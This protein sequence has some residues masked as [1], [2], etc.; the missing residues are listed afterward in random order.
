VLTAGLVCASLTVLPS[1]A[2][3]ATAADGDLVVSA[4]SQLDT[5]SGT[6]WTAGQTSPVMGTVV[7]AA[8]GPYREFDFGSVRID[9]GATL[10]LVGPYPAVIHAT[11]DITIAGT[12]DGAGNDT[13]P[14]AGGGRGGT[15]NSY[16]AAEGGAGASGG[17]GGAIVVGQNGLPGES[18][19]GWIGGLGGIALSG[20][21]GGG[22]G[23]TQGPPGTAGLCL[24]PVGSEHGSGGGGGRRLRRH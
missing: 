23:A 16:G 5:A 24:G 10:T 4:T 7:S 15:L 19:G 20:R 12:L 17:G 22:P 11:G 21:C 14:G 2:H 13:Q 9:A 8:G 6:L 1:E 18:S 3:A